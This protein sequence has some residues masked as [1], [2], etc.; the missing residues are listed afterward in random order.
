MSIIVLGSERAA[1]ETAE[2]AMPFVPAVRDLLDH[3]AAELAAEY[4][5]LMEAASDAETA[6]QQSPQKID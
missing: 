6:A 5:R 4:I 3:V 1:Q 2:G